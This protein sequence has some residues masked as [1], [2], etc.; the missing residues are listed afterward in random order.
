LALRFIRRSAASYLL[1]RQKRSRC[2]SNSPWHPRL[3]RPRRRRIARWLNGAPSPALARSW[4]RSM[5]CQSSRLCCLRRRRRPHDPNNGANLLSRHVA[6]VRRQHQGRA[7][8]CGG[9]GLSVMLSILAQ[10]GTGEHEV[11]PGWNSRWRDL[12][13]RPGQGPP[14]VPLQCPEPEWR[15]PPAETAPSPSSRGQDC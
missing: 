7:W 11:G 13:L 1:L 14:P 9:P 5:Q 12:R 6:E 8:R 4:G 3:I 10:A 2:H 15:V